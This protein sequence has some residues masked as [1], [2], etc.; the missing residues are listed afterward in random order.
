M[1]QSEIQAQLGR[2]KMNYCK[3]YL[4]PLTNIT[5][6]QILFTLNAYI[7]DEFVDEIYKENKLLVLVKREY[8]K[9]F[10]GYVDHRPFMNDIKGLQGTFVV[11]TYEVLPAQ[12]QAFKDALMGKQ[13]DPQT[14]QFIL[15][16]HE[17]RIRK[18]IKPILNSEDFVKDQLE[19]LYGYRPDTV[20]TRFLQD[21]PQPHYILGIDIL[22]AL[23][24]IDDYYAELLNETGLYEPHLKSIL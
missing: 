5:A 14:I 2:I 13:L 16:K 18:L 23:S 24:K 12:R 1:E 19:R 20:M 15:Q 22:Y 17:P 6:R 21:S 9:E 8:I 11:L 3:L 7:Y 10:S 4:L